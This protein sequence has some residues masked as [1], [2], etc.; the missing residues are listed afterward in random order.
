MRDRLKPTTTYT[1]R[2]GDTLWSIAASKL[3]RR[4]PLGR[5]RQ[6][7]RPRERRRHPARPDPQALH[8][9]LPRLGGAAARASQGAAA[10]RRTVGAAA[11]HSARRAP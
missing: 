3:G 2:T 11:Q 1:V 6:A 8:G 7:Q 9:A 5:H 10:R 4:R